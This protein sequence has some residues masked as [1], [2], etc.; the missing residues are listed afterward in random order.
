MKTTA[1]LNAALA[2]GLSIALLGG[3]VKRDASL[4]APSAP[5]A[6]VASSAPVPQVAAQ[7]PGSGIGAELKGQVDKARDAD[8]VIMEGAEKTKQAVDAATDT[9][10]DSAAQHK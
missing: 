5:D 8:R 2:A 1:I 4:A 9:P 3:C 6:A 7:A 10:A